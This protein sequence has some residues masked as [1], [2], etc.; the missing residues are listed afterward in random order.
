[1]R[2]KQK[3]IFAGFLTR[4]L[5]LDYCSRIN[6]ILR[7]HGTHFLSPTCNRKHLKVVHS[8][9][10]NGNFANKH[11]QVQKSRDKCFGQKKAI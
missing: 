8:T 5:L 9:I 7:V 6:S 10:K 3:I 11:N 1:M 4:K 2:Q